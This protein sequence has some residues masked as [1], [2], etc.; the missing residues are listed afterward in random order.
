LESKDVSYLLQNGEQLFTEFGNAVRDNLLIAT[1]GWVQWC[2]AKAK[3]PSAASTATF[4][5]KSQSSFRS[6]ASS[7]VSRAPILD[8]RSMPYNTRADLRRESPADFIGFCFA[9]PAHANAFLAE[10]G[11]EQITTEPH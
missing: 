2:R 9:D 7:R 10:F 6:V 5:V 3:S 4:P 1:E 11:G 8:S